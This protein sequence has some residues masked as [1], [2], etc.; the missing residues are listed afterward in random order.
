MPSDQLHSHLL[1]AHSFSSSLLFTTFICFA[2][3]R[4]T[5]HMLKDC[6]SSTETFLTNPDSSV[7]YS[8]SY[9]DFWGDSQ[10]SASSVLMI[11]TSDTASGC[12]LW[13]SVDSDM[14]RN[15]CLC[16]KWKQNVKKMHRLKIMQTAVTEILKKAKQLQ[17][18]ILLTNAI[19]A[20]THTIFQVDTAQMLSC[21]QCGNFTDL[22]F[23]VFFFMQLLKWGEGDIEI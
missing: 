22:T 5:Y 10:M 15:T 20:E 6:M 11:W 3:P 17:S 7:L 19:I 1:P 8:S 16:E 9:H 18:P 4:C 14:V 12:E 23:T 13:L 21:C 2:M